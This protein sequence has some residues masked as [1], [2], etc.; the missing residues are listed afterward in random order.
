METNRNQK[1]K[2]KNQN[3]NNKKIH[4][5]IQPKTFNVIIVWHEFDQPSYNNLLT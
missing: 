2:Q 3:H 1:Q 4:I 5:N